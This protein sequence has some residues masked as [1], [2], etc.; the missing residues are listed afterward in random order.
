MR[1]Q[2]H[3]AHSW[4]TW[5][6]NDSKKLKN[7]FPFFEI[8]LP[9]CSSFYPPSHQI[10]TRQFS[11]SSHLSE[12]KN[13][14]DVL[15]KYFTWHT[16]TFVYKR[17]ESRLLKW[18][19]KRKFN[20][21]EQFTFT[22]IWILEEEKRT[23]AKDVKVWEE[24]KCLTFLKEWERLSSTAFQ[25]LNKII[26]ISPPQCEDALLISEEIELIDDDDL[27]KRKYWMKVF[28]QWKKPHN[29]RSKN[30]LFIELFDSSILQ[31]KND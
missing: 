12:K 9:T 1:Y 8:F 28:T 15:H 23:W 21:S 26:E 6:F 16:R 19:K 25:L 30:W 13:T 3:H 5:L 4:W 17:K 31:K 22:F 10:R 2:K 18:T 7:F 29:I 27:M 24:D 14:L 20:F 11:C